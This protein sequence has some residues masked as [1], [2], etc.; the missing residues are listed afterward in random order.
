VTSQ[1]P[2]STPRP[3][4]P[5]ATLRFPAPAPIEWLLLVTGALLVYRYRWILD[6]STIYYRYVDNL[7]F[8]GRGLVFNQGEFVEGYSSPLWIL[9]LVATRATRL[10][11]WSITT[12]TSVASYAAFWYA[13]VVVNR[14][15]QG[16]DAGPPINVPM[17]LLATAYAPLCYFSSGSEFPFVQLAAAAVALYALRPDSRALQ[18]VLGALPLVRNEFVVPLL[19]AGACGWFLT[20]RTPWWLIASSLALGIGWLAFRVAYYADFFPN[21]FYLKDKISFFEGYHYLRSSFAPYGFDAL[22]ASVAIALLTLARR[23][24]RHLCLE[25]RAFMGIVAA[26]AVPYVLKVGGDMM[27]YRTLAFPFCLAVL[28][29][30]GVME[31]WLTSIDLAATVR[32]R[33]ILA[34]ALGLVSFVNYPRFLSSH[35]VF[36]Q[37][38]RELDRGV[39]DAAWHRHLPVLAF[40]GERRAEDLARLAA[41]RAEPSNQVG[42]GTETLCVDMFNDLQKRYVHGYGLTEPILAR[43]D[44]PE[45][46]PGHKND[47]IGL[48]KEIMA[49]RLRYPETSVG[50]TDRAIAGGVAP[51]W[52]VV[53]RDK[54]RLV[55]ERMYNSHEF[56]TNLQS[57]FRR[58]GSIE[59]TPR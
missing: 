14:A 47:L 41:Y 18:V 46:R 25:R 5:A 58:I 35:P 22:V 8:R 2:E 55:E 29:T 59:Q 53:N 24:D 4:T 37:E 20:R 6:D 10:D 12:A 39:S 32:A 11:Y 33:F 23:R 19:V 54:I 52:M 9:W 57:A 7:L 3:P 45:Q 26:S 1:P 50:V 28:S 42:I 16:D 30:G 13:A 21:P 44:V 51:A 48:A 34:A 40:N 43:V 17:V 56:F 31:R 38:E 27:H 36:G 15:L 49:I